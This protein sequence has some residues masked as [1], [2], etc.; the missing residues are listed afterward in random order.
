MIVV[1]DASVLINLCRVGQARL[2]ELL[3]KDVVIP[4][5][6]A[7]EFGRL[8]AALSRFAG[9]TLPPGV[10]QQYASI[11]PPMLRSATGLDAGETAALALA[12]EIHA[13]AILVDERRGHGYAIRLGLRPLEI[14][15]ILLQAKTAGVLTSV[16]PVIDA[17]R[18]DAGFW[19]SDSLRE[20][21]LRLA[22]ER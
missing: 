11:V 22:G 6:V 14:L 10:R 17:L 2:F 5:E 9:L 21:V 16:E 4:P 3:F 18:R 13:A 20:Q 12:V 7:S 1:A 15:G 19:L 8:T